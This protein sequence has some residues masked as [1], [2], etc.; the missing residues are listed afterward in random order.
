MYPV[1]CRHLSPILT[2][3]KFTTASTPSAVVDR[4][5]S[6][7]TSI[8]RN[9][10]GN[11]TITQ[12]ELGLFSRG[13]MIIASHGASIEDA[14]FATRYQDPA[15][16][17]IRPQLNTAAGSG[18][19]GTGYALIA[20]FGNTDTDRY[21]DSQV[22]R[23]TFC[24]PQLLAWRITNNGAVAI[25]SGGTQATVSRGGAGIINITLS[26]ARAQYRAAAVCAVSASCRSAR[27]SAF[28]G[29]T[30]Q[31]RT[32]DVA[33]AVQDCDIILFVLTS[34]N[35]DES[36]RRLD[37][38][39]CPQMFPELIFGRVTVT[40]GTPA[41]TIGG[42]TNGVDYTVTDNG[43]GDYTITLVKDF[44]RTCLA[45]PC[46]T[47]NRA[48]LLATPTVNSFRVGVFNAAGAAADDT[49]DFMCL[50]YHASSGQEF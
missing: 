38:L 4:G 42:A 1:R 25:A 7:F 21:D 34:G 9:S 18:D 46:A 16:G 49:F 44:L 28:D 31:I 39:R 32:T 17:I 5:A 10:A 27:I 2:G 33:A 29:Q 35:S 45:I 36:A 41:V 12:A 3:L 14:G 47:D 22:V 6:D 43:V 11:A 15:S 50:G 8:S 30:I 26:P 23:S 13:P 24:D 40:A 37:V 19:D 20:G 48:Q